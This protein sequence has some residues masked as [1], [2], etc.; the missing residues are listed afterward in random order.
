MVSTSKHFLKPGHSPA[1]VCLIGSAE[2]ITFSGDHV[3]AEVSPNPLLTLKPKATDERPRSL[4][5]YIDSLRKLRSVDAHVGYS[6]HRKLIYDLQERIPE[7]NDQHQERKEHVTE[8]IAE[9]GPV[10]AYHLMQEFF[11]NLP[12]T[13]TFPGMS[14]I[15]GHL[16]LLEDEFRATIIETDVIKRYNLHDRSELNRLQ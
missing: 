13:E 15:I 8:I 12:V 6:G 5:E 2:G 4:P 16:D 1:S 9:M 7:I 14:E 3:L 10:A 11:Q